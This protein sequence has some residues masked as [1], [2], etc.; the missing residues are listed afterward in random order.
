VEQGFGSQ[1]HGKQAWSGAAAGNR[2][3]TL[4]KVLI[5]GADIKSDASI[6]ALLALIFAIDLGRLG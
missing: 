6:N 5:N 1:D 2:I 4:P 3:A